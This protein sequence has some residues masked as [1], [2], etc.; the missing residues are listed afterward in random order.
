MKGKIYIA[1]LIITILIWSQTTISA[2]IYV[3]SDT[4]DAGVGTF[5]AAIDSVN[6]NAGTDTIY[7][8][9]NDATVLGRRINLDSSVATITEAVVIDGTRQQ[10]S[11]GTKFDISNAWIMIDGSNAGASGVGIPIEA[12]NCEIYGLYIANFTL[13]GIHVNGDAYDNIIIGAANKGNVISGN[14]S[15]GIYINGGDNFSIKGNLIGLDTTG[16]IAESNEVGIYAIGTASNGRIGSS[17]FADRN[18]ISGNTTGTSWDGGIYIEGNNDTIQGNFIGTDI[19]GVTAVPNTY[20]I[21]FDLASSGLQIGGTN[22]ADGNIISGNTLTGIISYGDNVK[23]QNNSIGS[24]STRTRRVGN[25][26]D[27]YWGEYRGDVILFEDNVIAANG[28]DGVFVA[29]NTAEFYGNMVGTC[30]NGK[31]DSLGNG[32]D[33]IDIE[34]RC[35]GLTVGGVNYSDKNVF[36]NNGECGIEA[37]A[38]NILIIGNLIGTD[39]T[40]TDSCGNGKGIFLG[41]QSN[42]AYIGGR[43]AD[44]A[45]IIATNGGIG[46]DI[47]ANVAKIYGNMIGVDST[48]LVK[49]GNTGTGLSCSANNTTMKIGSGTAAGR[50]IISCNGSNGLYMA[51]SNVTIKGNYIG[52]DKNGTADFGNGG[53]GIVATANVS[54]L[55]IG[56]S[57]LGDR[58]II[59]ASGS[60]GIYCAATGVNI[61]R[62]NYVGTDVTGTS[63]TLGNT[64]T[65]IN[66][67]ANASGTNYVGGSGQY[68]GNLI[69]MNGGDGLNITGDDF[70]IEGNLIGTDVT[71]KLDYGNSN[72]G[73]FMGVN[74]QRAWIGAAA[75]S[76]RNIIAGNGGDGIH[77]IS[78]YV[79]VW[80]NFIGVNIDGDSL[81][82]GGYGV[83][84]SSLNAG[85]DSIGS[86]RENLGNVISGN[87]LG[88]IRT[89]GRNIAIFNNMIGVDSLG[90]SKIPNNGIGIST[91]TINAYNLY[92]G[93]GTTY[94]PNI[95]AGNT[96]IGIYIESVDSIVILGNYIGTD[97]TGLV[98]TIGNGSYGIRFSY[99][100]AGDQ[101]RIW[102]GDFTDANMNT[103]AFNGNKAVSYATSETVS[104]RIARNN[105]YAN[106]S[107][108]GIELNSG[109]LGI[110]APTIDYAAG[111]SISGSGATAGALVHL[112]LKDTI[113]GNCEGWYKST[114][115][116]DGSGNFGFKDGSLITGLGYLVSQTDGKNSSEFSSCIVL[117]V[118]LIYFGAQQIEEQIEISWTTATEIN[119]DYFILERSTD[120]FE[121]EEIAEIEGNGNSNNIINY[122]F[123]DNNPF[124]GINYYRLTQYDYD[125]KNET[126]DVIAINY[127]SKNTINIQYHNHQ[128]SFLNQS[129]ESD[130][131]TLKI[132]NNMGA[133]IKTI[134]TNHLS[135]LQI[136]TN[137]FA[138]GNYHISLYSNNQLI[139]YSFMNY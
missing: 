9:I 70:Y 106:G 95:I 21:V 82:N 75:Y 101:E 43:S 44:S 118:E 27:G 135:T 51:G 29:G 120:G 125:G 103:I 137:K 17:A 92:I 5:R 76:S 72:D 113:M 134:E 20:G 42:F 3:V 130:Q 34:Y 40:G 49:M 32:G 94:G 89:L 54:T 73:I 78:D 112:F 126:F 23:V 30:L 81:G 2:K 69:C 1:Q 50:N 47:Y 71:G 65:G 63:M 53:S 41:S 25:G 108:G 37:D 11:A 35:F 12:A 104:G 119:N 33:G 80:N 19:T 48:G 83:Y 91:S 123:T 66:F 109:N 15:Y 107:S 131:G 61:V 122:V 110:A 79:R 139:H 4:T 6:A 13:Y 111:D 16:L 127:K 64:G 56:G 8:G 67:T 128:I 124:I 114:V 105:M 102:V 62:N 129:S 99:S 74:T 84:I 97:K 68:E 18:Y 55:T 60:F 85:T 90:T 10:D 88:G 59:S 24:D 36:A 117:P 77:L 116:A 100:G 7:F 22:F 138:Q 39:L 132:Y 93:N 57:N 45:N 115:T 38:D 87:V 52:V 14:T 96:G 86:P 28:D 98:S 121:F 136:N 26:A 58:N 31:G 133:I 46:L